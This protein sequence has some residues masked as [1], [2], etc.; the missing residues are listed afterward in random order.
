MIWDELSSELQNELGGRQTREKYEQL[1]QRYRKEYDITVRSG[2]GASRWKYFNLFNS[3]FPKNT[4]L[5]ME[6]VQELGDVNAVGSM[7]QHIINQNETSSINSSPTEIMDLENTTHKKKRTS[8]T[9]LKTKALETF[10][11]SCTASNNK[12]D[13][14]DII[15]KI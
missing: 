12:Q 5:V 2:S 10:I 8:M 9:E 4:K 11:Q 3:T 14:F 13:E 15:K 7:T 6:D 1:L